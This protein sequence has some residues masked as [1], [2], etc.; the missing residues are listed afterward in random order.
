VQPKTQK[1]ETTISHF[2]IYVVIESSCT[3]GIYLLHNQLASKV[4]M[5]AR[6]LILYISMSLDGY[7]A[8]E[9]DDLSWLGVVQQEG[10]DYGYEAFNESVDTYIVGRKTY[11]IVL[12]LTGGVFPQ[13]ER[14]KCYII[15]RQDRKAEN[16]VE[17][18]NGDL[19]A[20]IQQLKAEEGKNIYC[21]GGAE[22]VKLLMEQGLIDEYII[23]VIPI[24]LG[25]GKRL[26]IGDTPTEQLSALP[27][28]QF[29]SGLVQL[30]YK[31]T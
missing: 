7:I 16:G 31:K 26:F 14:H 27:A 15:T 3:K 22:L 20:L 6:K 9:N 11:E 1:N 23:S 8:T 29:D 2:L 4:N 13:A 10:E 25:N 5:A 18:Y 12:Q 24:L 30:H 19:N 17:F 28:K 21:D